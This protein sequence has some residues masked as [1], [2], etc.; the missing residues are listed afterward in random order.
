MGEAKR[1]KENEHNFGLVP[2]SANYRGLVI[3]PPIE[4]QG[5]S[6]LIKSNQLDPQELRFALLF[7][8]HLVW[9]SSRAVHIE[10][11]PDASFLE[12]TEVLTRP[13]YTYFGDI[14]QGIAKGQMQA[15][16]DLELSEPG[17]WALAQGE[18]SF[19]WKDK[20]IEEGK[21]A[22]VEL[23]RAIPIPQQDVPLAEILEFKERRKD[24][25]VLLRYKLESLIS[26]IE[27]STDK[28]EALNNSIKEL[29]Q[30]CSNLLI[31]GKEWQFPVYL[32]NI[33]ASFNLTATKL[34]PSAGVGWM[35]GQPYG[36]ASASMAAG[37]G[38]AIST[39]EIK[40]DFG[41]RSMKKTMSPYNYAY[42]INCEL[43]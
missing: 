32:S 5:T 30:A 26:I 21:G 43:R 10:S 12:R 13:E 11:N 1:R 22:L 27:S 28:T 38:G 23:H 35:M 36:M 31:L 14:A 20:L 15:F 41:L 37:V 16:K 19:L 4:I 6:L 17:V 2:K 3:S 33:K 24:E 25:L 9:P 40:G 42:R 39:L 29:D 8:D 34:A 7:W 18:S